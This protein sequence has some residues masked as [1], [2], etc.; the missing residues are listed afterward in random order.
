MCAIASTNTG[1][2]SAAPIQNR[3]VMSVSSEFSSSGAAEMV[4]GSKAIPLF[5]QS[6]AV[7]IVLVLLG[8][9]LELSARSKTGNDL[10]A[11][12][13][14]APTKARVV[15]GGDENRPGRGLGPVRGTPPPDRRGRRS[16]HAR[17]R[18]LPVPSAI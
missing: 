17:A 16:E 13:N 6:P 14:L 12:L 15:F 3:R 8:Q 9:M 10:R 11:L 7:I 18:V 2:V 4:F 1:S 5:G